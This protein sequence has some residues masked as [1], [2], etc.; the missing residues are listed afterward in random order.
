MLCLRYFARYNMIIDQV[1]FAAGR[2]IEKEEQRE[3]VNS[4][5]SRPRRIAEIRRTKD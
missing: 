3:N 2:D 1:D 5:G 4:E